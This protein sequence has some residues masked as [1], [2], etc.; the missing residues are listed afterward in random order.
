[1]VRKEEHHMDTR[2][3]MCMEGTSKRIV[4]KLKC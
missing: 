2:R 4:E 3:H 1:M